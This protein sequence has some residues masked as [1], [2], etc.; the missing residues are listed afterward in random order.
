MEGVERKAHT[1]LSV[2]LFKITLCLTEFC[3]V[4]GLLAVIAIMFKI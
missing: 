1:N 4:L 2:S 3:A